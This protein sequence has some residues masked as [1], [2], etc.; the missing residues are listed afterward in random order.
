[1]PLSQEQERQVRL[2]LDRHMRPDGTYQVPLD[3]K[4]FLE[5]HISRGVF[6]SDIM[7]SGIYTAQF[8]FEH[9]ELFAGKNVLDMG[10]GPGTLGLLMALRGASHVDLVDINPKAVS[11]C[12]LNLR[13]LKLENIEVFE[14]DLFSNLPPKKYEL[15]TF[16]HPF[17]PEW[18]DTFAEEHDPDLKRSMLGGTDL[19]P[20]FIAEVPERLD[21]NGCLV[22]PYFHF[23]G[24]ENDPA[25]AIENS[26]LRIREKIAVESEQ[27]LQLGAFSIYLMDREEE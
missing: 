8:L 7:S 22:M 26:P 11:D 13:N 15:I 5:L 9:P 21:P 16:N 23:A 20:R 19:L 4:D 12:A 24:P 25:Q 14:S 27:G 10:S 3:D 6:A 18:P 1:M 17:F 2:Q